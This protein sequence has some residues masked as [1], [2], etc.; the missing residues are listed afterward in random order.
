MEISLDFDFWID[1]YEYCDEGEMGSPFFSQVTE[2][3][4]NEITWQV[5]FKV[6]FIRTIVLFFIVMNGASGRL[7][8]IAV[9]VT[10]LIGKPFFP[11]PVICKTNFE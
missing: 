9:V 4:T 10:R 1:F 5:I 8:L 11:N 7:E 6:D 2:K 3:G